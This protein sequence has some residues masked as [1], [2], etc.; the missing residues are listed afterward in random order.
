MCAEGERG[1]PAGS[2]LRTGSDDSDEHV[3][4]PPPKDSSDGS[5]Q[6]TMETHHGGDESA[7]HALWVGLGQAL[8]TPPAW[9]LVKVD[10]AIFRSND[11]M[12]ECNRS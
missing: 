5:F 8:L 12:E 4:P 11:T 1:L 9:F 6:I 7:H 3:F 10:L 2:T